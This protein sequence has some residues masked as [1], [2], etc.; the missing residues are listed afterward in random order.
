MAKH[1]DHLYFFLLAVLVFFTLVV[2]ILVVIFAVKYRREKHP[3]A[4]PIHG[5]IPLEITWSL[6]PLALEMVI[7]VWGG[8]LYFQMSRPP[9]ASMETK[10]WTIARRRRVACTAVD[11]CNL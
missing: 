8:I 6:I 1:V 2:V 5:N 11:P 9:A 10:P 3:V 4:V 7:F